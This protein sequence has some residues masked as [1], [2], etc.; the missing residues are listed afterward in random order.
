M[1]ARVLVAYATRAGS[2]AGVATAIAETPI[3]RGS[4]VGVAPIAEGPSVWGYQGAMVGSAIQ[5]GQRLPEAIAFV[6]DNRQALSRLL[7]G[8]PACTS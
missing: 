2:T 7:A 3:A 6:R 5:G 1:I 8:C 4:A